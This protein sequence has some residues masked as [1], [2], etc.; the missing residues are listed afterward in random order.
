MLAGS[1]DIGNLPAIIY[2]FIPLLLDF[3]IGILF[4][5]VIEGADVT[6]ITYFI[7]PVLMIFR[8]PE[9]QVNLI[10]IVA[11]CFQL[12][13]DLF[14]VRNNLGIAVSNFLNYIVLVDF[15]IITLNFAI[16]FASEIFITDIKL[17]EFDCFS[18]LADYSC[19]I[20][21]VFVLDLEGVPIHLIHTEGKLLVGIS[22]LQFSTI[23]IGERLE[24]ID[25]FFTVS[26]VMPFLEIVV[27]FC[28]GVE[29]LLRHNP[30]GA[31]TVVLV[32]SRIGRKENTG[33]RIDG[34]TAGVRGVEYDMI[35]NILFNITVMRGISVL[36][37]CSAF[38]AVDNSAAAFI[39]DGNF[40]LLDVIVSAIGHVK[41]NGLS[42]IFNDFPSVLRH[43][44][45]HVGAVNVD[46][47]IFS[48]AERRTC[49]IDCL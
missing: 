42:F 33:S 41:D 4:L 24:D 23:L 43:D 21:V 14:R 48:L 19:M 16:L 17:G 38:Q 28:R 22:R 30:A 40:E 36:F 47:S 37:D 45:F 20:G 44:V 13:I 2:G 39:L 12:H 9:L 29:I 3:N 5:V 25:L 1:I 26:M 35:Q 8:I 10:L 27:P 6:I 18:S 7:V 49:Q 32:Y 31:C 34:Q 46:G 15:L 11:M